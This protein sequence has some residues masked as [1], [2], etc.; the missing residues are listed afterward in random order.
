VILTTGRTPTSLTNI[1]L[2][3][4][5]AIR[6][7]RSKTD[8]GTINLNTNG[9]LPEA[10]DQLISAG[11]DSIRVSINSARPDFHERYYSPKGFS[12]QDVKQSITLMKKAEKHVSLNYFVLPG[13]T[14]DPDEFD[15]FCQLIDQH[16]PDLIQL[17][18]L[19]MDPEWYCRTVEHQPTS[20]PLGILSW[21][22]RLK[23][24]FP[25]LRFG[26]FNP[27]LQ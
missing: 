17:R 27:P 12:L 3:L 10:V 19:N 11:L 20:P 25:G 26:Y 18:N 14:D 15:A 7:I 1:E 5:K 16:H 13:F 21:H 22:Q 4:A 23:E 8:R 24:L 9:S 6:L 2:T